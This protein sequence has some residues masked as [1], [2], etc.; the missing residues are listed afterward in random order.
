[1]NAVESNFMERRCTINTGGVGWL[2]TLHI[3]GRDRR[4]RTRE[5]FYAESAC[6]P[7]WNGKA[8]C[9]WFFLWQ[10]PGAGRQG[11]RVGLLTYT[12][13]CTSV[14][15]PPTLPTSPTLFSVRTCVTRKVHGIHH[16]FG[17]LPCSRVTIGSKTELTK[18]CLSFTGWMGVKSEPL[19]GPKN[20]V[21]FALSTCQPSESGR[22]YANL[23]QAPAE[24][25]AAEVHMEIKKGKRLTN[26]RPRC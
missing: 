24:A 22:P 8:G 25:T 10:C 17:G 4:T 23:E 12:H 18:M 5:F 7:G 2:E 16:S 21:L 19:F 26:S 1:M 14:T 9:M 20:K 6:L 13:L 11:G 15:W 3:L